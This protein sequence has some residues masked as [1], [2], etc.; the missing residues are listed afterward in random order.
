MAK[1]MNKTRCLVSSCIVSSPIGNLY[2]RVCKQGLHFLSQSDEIVG[3]EFQP[4]ESQEVR[5]ICSEDGKSAQERI[6]YTV[7]WL[8]TYFHEIQSLPSLALPSMC[9]SV[10]E[11]T[12]RGKVWNKLA[13]Y[14]GPGCTVSYGELAK[15][16]GHPGAAQ[17]VGTAMA[18]NPF[19]I[20]VPCHR[21][22]RTDGTMGQ[23]ARGTRNE[24]KLW[25]LEHEGITGHKISRIKC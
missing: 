13:E 19:Q 9:P 1:R 6:A 10:G 14:V 16:S 7:M 15:V 11:G 2:V 4:D 25:L 23:Y 18:T 21:V 17:A 20:I 22:I 5:I 24:V 12:F 3:D 8:H